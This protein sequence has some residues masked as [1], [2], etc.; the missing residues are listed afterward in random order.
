[1]IAQQ[2]EE[3]LQ[4]MP[5]H[6][7]T[8]FQSDGKEVTVE[9]PDLAMLSQSRMTLMVNI[10]GDRWRWVQLPQVTRIEGISMQSEV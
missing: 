8:L 9:H 7:F 6:P 2:V 3:L 10:E 4:A 1:M 5:F